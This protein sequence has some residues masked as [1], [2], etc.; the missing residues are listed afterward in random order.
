M[1][2]RLNNCLL[3]RVRHVA[4]HVP[5]ERGELDEDAGEGDDLDLEPEGGEQR[6][7]EGGEVDGRR[8]EAL[9]RDIAHEGPNLTDKGNGKRET[10]GGT[11]V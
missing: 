7:E 9:G 4:E 1:E 8:E 11:R 3:S 6:A 10:V 2:T 5:R